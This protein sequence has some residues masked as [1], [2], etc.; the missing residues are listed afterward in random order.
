MAKAYSY[1]RF[2]TADQSKGDSL[3]RQVAAAENYAKEHGFELDN[4]L[5]F[6]DLGVSAFDQSNI[7]TGALGKF[8]ELVNEG[9]IEKG[10]Y[11]LVE[12]LDRL[13]RA[14][15]MEAHDLF[16]KLITAGINIVTLSDRVTYNQEDLNKNPM[17][18]VYSILI[19]SRASEESTIKS[20]RGKAAWIGKKQNIKN[21]P[22][23]A[24]CPYWMQLSKDKTKFELIPEKANVV[25]RILNLAQ[26]GHGNS[27]ITKILNKEMVPTFSNNPN[28]WQ[29]SYI[30]KVIESTAC[31][32]TFSM[33]TTDSSGNDV[34]EKIKNY[35]P[36]II[37]ELEWSKIQ[38]ERKLRSKK[39]GI[40]KGANGRVSNIFSGLLFC[41]Y[42]KGSMTM[43]AETKKRLGNKRIAYVACSNARRGLNC[44]FIRWKYDELEELLLSTC[45][46]LNFD[47][48]L[49]N[50]NNLELSEMEN[51]LFKLKGEKIETESRIANLIDAIE[52]GNKT[53]STTKRILE[54]EECLDKQNHQIKDLEE[55]SQKFRSKI[56]ARH[57]ISKTLNNI[58]S[59]LKTSEGDEL[60]RLRKKLALQIRSTIKRI[61][62]SPGGAFLNKQREALILNS[63]L[64]GLTNELKNTILSNYS[65]K[66][67]KANRFAL[68]I[69]EGYKFLNVSEDGVVFD[70]LH[71]MSLE[72]YLTYIESDVGGL[73]PP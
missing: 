24:R 6:H 49:G 7:R 64:K 60:N 57:N 61:F 5:S 45:K 20:Q 19:M 37:S 63:D 33:H 28:G 30:Q 3:R 18:L 10:S 68:I 1:I 52:T 32:G 56:N 46:Q 73:T 13:S 62:L 58:I 69:F 65:S 47:D 51:N 41:A 9:R 44:N 38:D 48:V 15:V 8:L 4:S 29:P 39:G 22:L 17:G 2:S 12:N 43:G 55:Q 59:L 14:N 72:E 31:Y 54:L 50:S 53:D 67:D 23:T 16:K 26:S 11:L 34:I 35:Y 66:P 42:C 25:K 36:A 70:R 27:S 71:E 21:K 40:N